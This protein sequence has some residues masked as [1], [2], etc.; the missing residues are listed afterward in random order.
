MK[1][2]D[3][4]SN[5]DNRGFFSDPKKRSHL[6][7]WTKYA[8]MAFQLFATLVVAVLAGMGIDH[9]LG[10]EKPIFTALLIPIFLFGF[11]Y[12]LYLDISQKK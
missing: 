7:L 11:L 6:L 4:D 2:E 1:N 3:R 12:K 10:L 5:E 8:G 9:L